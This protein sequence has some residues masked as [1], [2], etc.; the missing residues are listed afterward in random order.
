MSVNKSSVA[1]VLFLPLGRGRG[2]EACLLRC[3]FSFP[4]ISAA[5]CAALSG[6]CRVVHTADGEEPK[7][8]SPRRADR[9]AAD[10]VAEFAYID[11]EG[12]GKGEG[13]GEGDDCGGG[14]VVRGG[15]LSLRGLLLII[16]LNL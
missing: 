15:V 9:D 14:A 1:R 12:E 3:T 13:K 2:R 10:T 6:E 16:S 11:E 7:A 5:R 8:D 4:P